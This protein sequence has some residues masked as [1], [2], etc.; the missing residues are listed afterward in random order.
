ML[1]PP[2]PDDVSDPEC[3]TDGFYLGGILT[4]FNKPDSHDCDEIT[5][6]SRRVGIEFSRLGIVKSFNETQGII[7]FRND[8]SMD[9]TSVSG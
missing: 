2:C 7:A 4:G 9:G 8:S 3:H 5:G 1:Y 6:I